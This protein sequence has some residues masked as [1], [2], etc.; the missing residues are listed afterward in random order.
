MAYLHQD[1]VPVGRGNL[2]LVTAGGNR[3]QRAPD[4]QGFYAYGKLRRGIIGVE[5]SFTGQ[6]KDFSSGL[7][8]FNA[9]YYDPEL[10]HF[11][12][13][14]TLV[15][16]PGN[17]FDY[18]RYM[19]GYGNPMRYNDPTGHCPKPPDKYANVICV[20]GFIPT[21][22]SEGAPGS[23]IVYQGDGRDFSSDSTGQSSRF[24][25]WI[26]A[27]TGEFIGDPIELCSLNPVCF[28]PFLGCR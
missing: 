12:S 4:D 14:D 7:L 5:R 24:Y 28:L 2:A 13:P 3:A 1:R 20:A 21:K 6:Q 19:Y 15:P 22:E 10:G 27:D 8:Y 26:N 23:W 18:N 11:L 9:R 17:L 25:F 16:D